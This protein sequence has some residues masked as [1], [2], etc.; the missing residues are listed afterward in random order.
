MQIFAQTRTFSSSGTF[1]YT[2]PPGVTSL[3][4]DAWGAGGSGG[5]LISGGGASIG[6]AHSYGQISV[7]TGQ[8][9]TVQV[10]KGGVASLT[11]NAPASQGG[12]SYVAL[13]NTTYYVLAE[14]GRGAPNDSNI[15]QMG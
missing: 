12:N 15:I 3:K 10:G 2:V 4:I 9:L 1:T 5:S 6:G 13:G 14:G 7:T 11:A 8:K